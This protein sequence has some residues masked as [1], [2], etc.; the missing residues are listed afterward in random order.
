MLMDCSV[1]MRYWKFEPRNP[2]FVSESARGGN[3]VVLHYQNSSH[4]ALWV[5]HEGPAGCGGELDGNL[6]F[7]FAPPIAVA[8]AS[9]QR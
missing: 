8:L 6:L 1:V 4:Q 2:E 9:D 7:A 3:A 5:N